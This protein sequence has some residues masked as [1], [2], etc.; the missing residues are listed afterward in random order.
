LQW[1]N[2]PRIVNGESLII[3]RWESRHFRNKKREY[4]KDEIDELVTNSKNNNIRDLYRGLNYFKKTYQ[5]RS[6]LMK[7]MLEIPTTF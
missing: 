3:V 7:D 4:L 2:N 5:S 1:L 6:N